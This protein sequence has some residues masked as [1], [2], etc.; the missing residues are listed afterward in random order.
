MSNLERRPI[1]KNSSITLVAPSPTPDGKLDTAMG[2]GIYEMARFPTLG[3]PPIHG[4]LAEKGF[5]PVSIDAR[6]RPQG[7]LTGDDWGRII[8]SDVLMLTA[9]TRT[10]AQTLEIVRRYKEANPRGTVIMGG[11]H[12]TFL[13]EECLKAGVDFVVRGEGEKT[14]GELLENL[15][16]DNNAKG[17]KGVSYKRGNE[18]IHE[19]LRPLL[20]PRE[21]A[22]LPRDIYDPIVLKKRGVDTV[23]ASRGCPWGC[24][25]CSVTEFF[26]RSHRGI[27]NDSTVNNLVQIKKRVPRKPVFFIDDNFFVEKHRTKALLRDLRGTDL[28]PWGSFTQLRVEAAFDDEFLN[29]LSGSGITA[30]YLGIESINDETLAGINKKTSKAE[31]EKAIR[32]YR[33][34]GLWVHGM[35]IAGL[36]GETKES[37]EETLEWAKNNVHS[38]QF[39]APIP[40]PK[41]IDTL[42]KEAEGRVL[43]KKY[44]LYDGHH[45]LIEPQ[46][47][48]PWELQQLIIQMNKEFYE[49][50]GFVRL[51]LKDAISGGQQS[52]GKR[53][54]NA[55]NSEAGIRRGLY[56]D[57]QYR[58]FAH[59]AINHMLHEPG[60]QD[61][62]KALKDWQPGQEI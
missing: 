58:A 24:E 14:I 20:T 40:L 48:T 51:I 46:N 7:I 34:A 23:A 57:F 32:L 16:N 52:F 31:I 2:M 12:A 13:A 8:N 4:V 38:A 29:L 15:I 44:H 39:A 53:L 60:T 22:E 19:D 1:T 47:F 41:T 17:V 61:Y 36:D 43:T 62:F 6:F 18:I 3:I 30:V 10:S 35:F 21:L 45:V 26:E 25:F 49:Y 9:I 50:K 28:I 37:M 55:W 5:K 27:P 42:K 56:K 33:E 59:W 11:F 54:T